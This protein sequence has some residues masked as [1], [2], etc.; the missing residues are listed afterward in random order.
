MT[1]TP[2]HAPATRT[3]LILLLSPLSAVASPSKP[4]DVWEEH[5]VFQGESRTWEDLFPWALNMVGCDKRHLGLWVTLCSTRRQI[6]SDRGACVLLHERVCVCVSTCV[7][8]GDLERSGLQVRTSLDPCLMVAVCPH[9][10]QHVLTQCLE[11]VYFHHL[12]L[13][14]LQLPSCSA[15]FVLLCLSSPS[16]VLITADS[17]LSLKG[18]SDITPPHTPHL[19]SFCFSPVPSEDTANSSAWFPRSA[20][21]VPTKSTTP[22][23]SLHPSD[24]I[25]GSSHIDCLDL[26]CI[27]LSLTCTVPS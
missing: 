17:G 10:I 5:L 8:C 12:T 23:I 3:I 2:S 24:P 14:P 26:S 27:T 9:G 20:A 1:L 18:K 21:W 11:T 25:T 7:T 13:G 6:P 22:S 19:K 4:R 16:P 15:K